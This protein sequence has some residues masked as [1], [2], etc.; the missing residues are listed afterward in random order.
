MDVNVRAAWP[1]STGEGVI[2]AVADSGVE[3]N[4]VELTNSVTGAPHYNFAAQTTDGAPIN[5]SGGGAHGTEVA[6]LIAERNT[7]R[8]VGVAPG[9][10]LASW[11]IFGTNMLLASDDRL[12][13]LYQYESNNVAVQN[14][15]WGSPG[16]TL[17]GPT[18]L[19]QIGISNAIAYGRL[20][21]GAIM[22]RSAGNDRASGANANDDGYP[23][24]PRVI[25]RGGGGCINGRAGD[26]ATLWAC[27]FVARTQRRRHHVGARRV[28][29][30][31]AW[32]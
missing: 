14:H 19:E 5:R 11:V 27:A 21:R 26:L 22:V 18:L 32:R 12:M 13:D 16:L 2:V 17:G 28:H 8:M 20:G 24:D 6:G 3:M 25:S 9:A 23:S 1:Y 7:A 31:S 4:Q 10:K 30:R 15:S 29:H